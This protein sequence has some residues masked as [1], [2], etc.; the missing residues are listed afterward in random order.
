MRKVQGLPI[1]CRAHKPESCRLFSSSTFLS[2]SQPEV[3]SSCRRRRR[4]IRRPLLLCSPT[5]LLSRI[6]VVAS[7]SLSG[8]P[9]SSTTTPARSRLVR[10]AADRALALGLLRHPRVPLPSSPGCPPPSPSR[11]PSAAGT[12]APGKASKTPALA[13]KAKVL[14]R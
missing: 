13:R 9:A 2:L 10:E 5:R 12:S 8:S 11:H 6:H 4:R 14:G 7:S 3:P 1:V